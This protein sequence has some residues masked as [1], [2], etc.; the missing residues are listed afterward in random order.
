MEKEEIS[1][2]RID[3]MVCASCNSEIDVSTLAPFSEAA[4]PN[5]GSPFSV[6]ARL[7]HYLLLSLIGAGGMG[8]VYE[9]YDETLDRIVAIKIMK[10]SLGDQPEFLESFR[11]EAQAAAKLNH[12]NIAQVYSIGVEKE[13]PYIVMELVPGN[14]LDKMIENPAMLNQTMAMK[15][16]M[17]IA[18]GLQLAAESNLI[19]GD[20][21]PE[22]I[23]LDDRYAAKLVDFGL[24]SAPNVEQTEIWGTSYYIAP[25]KVKRE[26]ADFR[27]DMYSLG[28][29]LYHAITKMPPFD[30]DDAVAVAKARLMYA[31]RPMRDF[32][33]DVDPDV[34]KII[35]KM[36]ELE[37]TKRY[38]SYLALIDDIR[39]YLDKA[40][41]KNTTG[42]INAAPAAEPAPQT[43]A[44]GG[45]KRIIIKGKHKHTQVQPEPTPEPIPEAIPEAESEEPSSGGRVRIKKRKNKKAITLPTDGGHTEPELDSTDEAAEIKRRAKRIRNIAIGI[46]VALLLIIVAVVLILVLPGG[47]DKKGDDKLGALNAEVA[48]QGIE[49]GL[50]YNIKLNSEKQIAQIDKAALDAEAIVSNAVALVER[51]M[52]AEYTARIMTDTPFEEPDFDDDSAETEAPAEEA[53]EAA[54]T[55]E[56]GEAAEGE[57]AEGEA[58][59]GDAEGEAGEE[60]AG[61][62]E[63]EAQ[64]DEAASEEAAETVAEDAAVEGDA[65]MAIEEVEPLPDGLPAMAREIYEL[66]RPV[67][68][69]KYVGD[70]V[71]KEVE[72]LYDDAAASTNLVSEINVENDSVVRNEVVGNIKKI[73]EYAGKADA[74]YAVLQEAAKDNTR[75]LNEAAAKLE[76]LKLEAEKLK[77]TREQAEAEEK[78]AEEARIAQEKK[79]QEEAAEKARED[80]ELAKVRGVVPMSMEEIKQHKYDRVIRS[81]KKLEKELKYPS[82]KA[83]LDVEIR[84]V[85]ALKSL[86]AF[87]VGKL[88]TGEYI[89][90]KTGLRIVSAD[91]RKIEVQKSGRK[92]AKPE[93]MKWEELDPATV[94]LPM[95]LTYLDDYES[96]VIKKLPLRERTD[97]YVNAAVY[98]SVLLGEQPGAKEKAKAYCDHAI[99]GMNS[100]RESIQELLYEL[101]FGNSEF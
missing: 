72:D 84:R 91:D 60:T 15:I 70:I 3:R 93:S 35:L 66:L 25:E 24:A 14:H 68:Y 81:I 52:G 95:I 48:K 61:E 77:L 82:A 16:G 44:S 88:S 98:I 83:A 27:S 64:D 43:P 40:Q 2:D 75:L 33:A 55:E 4:C 37:P 8:S 56:A 63:A 21:K 23:L 20:I 47:G 49:L 5:C 79:A 92:N 69:S 28:A 85:E 42:V 11:R 86:K 67:R 36:L 62:D 39:A 30:G 12:P 94:I 78:A 38:P 57:V 80:A 89:H 19:H 100:R 9:A 34:E 59:E 74:R 10:K 96:D 54:A 65:A 50:V 45:G 87:L 7:G 13:Q 101:D 22:N 76:A 51:E 99:E 17:D 32:R 46:G 26:K 97:V 53:G 18:D 6:P 29:T 90:K 1:F 58:A 73:R 71:L 41:P 31:P